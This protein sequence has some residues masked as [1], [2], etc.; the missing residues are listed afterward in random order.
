MLLLPPP[1]PPLFRASNFTSVRHLRPI[2]L[3]GRLL[4]TPA[5]AS[6]KVDAFTEYSGYLFEL[7]SSEAESLTEYNISKIAAI[8][9]KKPLILLRRLFQIAN[10]LGKWFALRYYDRVMERADLMFE[11]RVMSVCSSWIDGP[12]YNPSCV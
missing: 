12:F 1:S 3:P 2:I 6:D 9:Q 4:A 5:A 7:S 11:V 10:T 8:Y